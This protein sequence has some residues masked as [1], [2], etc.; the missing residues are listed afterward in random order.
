MS[1]KKDRAKDRDKGKAK[2][3]A[4]RAKPRALYEAADPRAPHK[5][6]LD[7]RDGDATVAAAGSKL[8]NFARHLDQNHDLSRGAIDRLIQFVIGP[9]GIAIEPLPRTKTGAIHR[10]LADRLLEL[11]DDWTQWPEVTWEHDWISVQHALGRALFRDGEVLAQLVTGSL[12]SLDHGTQVPFSIEM[13]EADHLPFDLNDPARGITQG[14]ERNAWGRPRAYHLHLNHPGAQ[15]LAYSSALF[16]TGGLTKRVPTD[17]ILHLK[18]ADRI[19]QARG[20]TKLAAVIRRLSDIKD[21]EDSERIAAKVAANL[22]AYVKRTV[23]ELMPD[24]YYYPLE[25]SETPAAPRAFPTQAGMVFDDLRP[26]EDVGVI[27][28][29]RPNPNVEAFRGGQLRAASAG[30]GVSYSSLA[31]DYNGTYSAQRQEL[32]EQQ[33]YYELLTALFVGQL[34]RPVWQR[35]VS[36][37]VASLAVRLPADL[38]PTT[39]LK[40]SY[41]GPAMLWIDP[42]KEIEAQVMAIDHCLISPPQVIRKRGDNPDDVIK[43]TDDWNQQLDKIHKPAPPAARPKPLRSAP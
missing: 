39:L 36:E 2:A 31:R 7:T 19:K 30:I 34:A 29:K 12:P 23:P 28:S 20:V 14:I 37:A 25:G 10:A 13:I 5:S 42:V 33:S 27:D 38:N 32:V 3:K 15:Q 35:F 4:P 6:W 18:L 43:Q 17:N 41:R 11:W 22:T 26:G 1:K 16:Y 8:R 40:A 9:N 21:Y 24:G